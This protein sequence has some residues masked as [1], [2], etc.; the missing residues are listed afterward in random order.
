[1]NAPIVLCSLAPAHRLA[2]VSHDMV[3]GR[4]EEIA[5]IVGTAPTSRYNRAV[6]A[7]QPTE[8]ERFGRVM[9]SSP[10]AKHRNRR[11]PRGGVQIKAR[12]NAAG[13][14]HAPLHEIVLI[15]ILLVVA[16]AVNAL[17]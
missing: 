5:A 4:A 17:G 7:R 2:F 9:T 8:H 10:A 13:C 15:T 6:M 1:M 12:F 14:D 16:R 3:A 11:R